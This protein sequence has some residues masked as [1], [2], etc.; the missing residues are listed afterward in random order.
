MSYPF[1]LYTIYDHPKDY[2]DSF[3]VRE[4][5]VTEGASIPCGAWQHETLEAARDQM[6]LRGL[7]CVPRHVDDDLNIVECWL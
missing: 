5:Q 2:P 7:I 1:T 6:R 4:W 3:V